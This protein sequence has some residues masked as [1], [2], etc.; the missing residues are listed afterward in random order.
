MRHVSVP[1]RL[2]VA[3]AASLALAS[4]AGCMSVSDDKSGRP[5]PSKSEEEQG[6]TAPDPDGGHAEPG[7]EERHAGGRQAVGPGRSGAREERGGARPAPASPSEDV[8]AAPAPRPSAGGKRPKPPG[9]TPEPTRGAP[10]TSV[11]PS[12]PPAQTPSPEPPSPT[13]SE[14]PSAPTEQPSASSAPEV[15]A[16]ALRT[17]GAEGFGMRGE[18]SASPQMGPV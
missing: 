12:T 3:F 14:Q 1:G 4:S 9:P 6:H 18:P 5:A 16:G 2:A 15:H 11:P 17:A 8:T 13:P 10:A 7:E